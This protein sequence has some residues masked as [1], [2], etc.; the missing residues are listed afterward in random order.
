M[1]TRIDPGSVVPSPTPITIDIGVV[2]TRTPIEATDLPNIASHATEAQVPTTITA[3][4]HTTDLHLIG[5]LTS[6]DGGRSQHK[7]QKTTLQTSTGILV[8][9]A[10]NT[11]DA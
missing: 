1:I 11:L 5:I 2:A 3:T 4:H 7:S 10:S 9:L 6:Q 8:N